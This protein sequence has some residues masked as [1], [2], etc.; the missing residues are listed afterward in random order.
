VR[1]NRETEPEEIDKLKRKKLELE[2][3]IH[4][5]ERERDAASKE[6]L[7]GARKA[8]ADIEEKL[9]PL[10]AAY[11]NEK[12]RGEEVNE[13]RKK[14]DEL[15]AKAEDAKRRFV[16]ISLISF[17]L[18]CLLSSDT[19]SPRLPTSS[20]LPFPKSKLGLEGWRRERQLRKWLREVVQTS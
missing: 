5:L 16:R 2:I 11:E 3:E 8:I 7:R 18:N 15:K 17:M 10:K 4:A 12:R 14:L 1:V 6:R 20:F 19:I 9:Q 13:A